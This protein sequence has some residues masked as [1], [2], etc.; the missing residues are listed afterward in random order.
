MKLRVKYFFYHIFIFFGGGILDLDKYILP[1][2]TFY[3]GS[4]FRLE[5][6]CI[7]VHTVYPL[8]ISF[9]VPQ[10]K[11]GNFWYDMMPTNTHN[12][13]L[14]DIWEVQKSVSCAPAG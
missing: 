2:Q 14:Q 4:H 6:F 1:W 13:Q 9:S 3:L 7:W 11:Q 10:V 12:Q 5:S 8:R